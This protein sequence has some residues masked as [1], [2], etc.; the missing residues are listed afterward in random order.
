MSDITET[1]QLLREAEE[2]AARL[3]DGIQVIECQLGE[4]SRFDPETGQPKPITA[5]DA[6]ILTARA[7]VEHGQEVTATKIGDDRYRL[8]FL[9]DPDVDGNTYFFTDA[10][11]AKA[12]LNSL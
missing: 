12:H 3:L 4:P 1:K 9:G 8:S 2:R 11:E 7:A 6:R 5:L 10:G